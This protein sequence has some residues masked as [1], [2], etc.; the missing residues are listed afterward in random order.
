MTL[1]IGLIKPSFSSVKWLFL[2][3]NQNFIVEKS[4]QPYTC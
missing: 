1:A 2:P 3:K 4:S